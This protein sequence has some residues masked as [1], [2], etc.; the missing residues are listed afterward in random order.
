MRIYLRNQKASVLILTLFVVFFLSVIAL[1]ISHA[2]RLNT[3]IIGRHI[4]NQKTLNIAQAAVLFALAEL[5]LDKEDNDY[6]CLNDVW[7][8]KFYN[9]D[10]IKSFKFKNSLGEES[11]EYKISIQDE[12]SRMNINLAS[13]DFIKNLLYQLSKKD[14]IEIIQLIKEYRDSLCQEKLI[15]SVYELG[16][17]KHMDKNIFWGEDINDND[18]LDGWEDDGADSLPVDNGNSI[19]DYGMKDYFT[20]FT[21]GKLNLNTAS[22]EILLSIPGITEEAVKSIIGMRSNQPF[23]NEDDLEDITLLSK[24]A[25]QFILRWGTVRSSLFRIVVSARADQA[26]NYKQIIAIADRSYQPI[27]I[28]YWREN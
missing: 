3:K 8:K 21:D 10:R 4:H 15:R 17:I 24:Q 22:A 27:K 19:L 26:K 28:I 9:L 23:E 18:F 11:G 25:K 12:C 6:D 2:M 7:H 13:A 16:K 5:K 20:I 1:S 14:N